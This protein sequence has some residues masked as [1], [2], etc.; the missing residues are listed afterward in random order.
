MS[1]QSVGW[2]CMVTKSVARFD[3]VVVFLYIINPKNSKIFCQPPSTD[4]QHWATTTNVIGSSSDVCICYVS[5][6]QTLDKTRHLISIA[7]SVTSSALIPIKWWPIAGNTRSSTLY[8]QLALRSF[9]PAKVR[10]IRIY[11]NLWNTTNPQTKQRDEQ[12]SFAIC[13]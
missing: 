10:F 11:R 3:Y 5:S 13:T 9:R 4:L 7:W 6:L 8:K 12:I 2:N 1:A